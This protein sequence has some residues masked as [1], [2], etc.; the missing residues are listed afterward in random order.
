MAALGPK[1]RPAD[2]EVEP[3]GFVAGPDHSLAAKR[4]IHPRDLPGE[5]ILLSKGDCSYRRIFEQV[6]EQEEVGRFSTFMGVTKK[7]AAQVDRPGS[8]SN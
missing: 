2:I 1:A 5:T 3:L 7:T 8:T 6:L 4:S